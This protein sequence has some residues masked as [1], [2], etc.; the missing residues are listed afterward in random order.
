MPT[1]PAIC[2]ALRAQ[3]GGYLSSDLAFKESPQARIEPV[4]EPKVERKA[5]ND[6]GEGGLG[7]KEGDAAE[8]GE[9]R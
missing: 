9:T 4:E 2:Y 6:E 7:A 3:G 1:H 5:E 8:A